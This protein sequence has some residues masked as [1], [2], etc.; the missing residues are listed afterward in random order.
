MEQNNILKANPEVLRGVFNLLEER[1]IVIPQEHVEIVVAF[2]T[3][4][5]QNTP[6]GLD[7]SC[8]ILGLES[9]KSK[10]DKQYF[11]STQEY[12]TKLQSEK[13]TFIKGAIYNNKPVFL[14]ELIEYDKENTYCDSCGCNVVCLGEEGICSNCLIHSDLAI[15]NNLKIE[16]DK[17]NHLKCSWN[18]QNID[19]PPFEDLETRRFING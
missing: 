16:C 13:L 15:K 18:P 12:T 17:C 14:R 19:V 3:N 2:M 7:F 4:W 11:L 8:F 5:L 1:N 10:M 6:R 9:T